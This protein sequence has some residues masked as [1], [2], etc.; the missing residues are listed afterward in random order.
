MNKK[1]IFRTVMIAS[2]AALTMTSCNKSGKQNDEVT[3]Q[4][5][6]AAGTSMK[7]AYVEVDSLMS[8]YKFCKD[9]TLLMTKK[10]Q[11]IRATLAQK[12][13]ALQTAAADFQQKVQ[14]NLYTRER[15]EQIQATLQKQQSDLQALQERLSSEFDAEQNKYN[16]ALRD[17]LQGFLKQYNKSKTYSLILSKAGDNILYADKTYDITS[18]V[19]NGLNKRYK[20]SEEMNSASGK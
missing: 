9:Y 17:S 11:N 8:Q 2:A 5:S 15:A 4:A 3:S 19:V 7:I 1:N 13:K 16:N 14:A 6:K 18:D 20:P 10:G 12:S